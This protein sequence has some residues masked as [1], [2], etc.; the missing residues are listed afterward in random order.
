[1][2]LFDNANVVRTTTER[3]DKIVIEVGLD[4]LVQTLRF[5][6]ADAIQEQID[7]KNRP[8]NIIVDNRNSKPI[9]TATKRIQAF[10]TDVEQIRVAV[11][12]AWKEIQKLTRVK[13]G[14]AIGSYQIWY[15]E[16]PIGTSPSAIDAVLKTFDGSK[17]Y[18]RIVGPLVAYGRKIY[19]RPKNRPGKGRGVV[20]PLKL[21]K[22]V[23]LRTN[24]A[25]FKVVRNKGIMQEVEEIL[26]RRYR[27]VA[28]AEDW[29]NT[30][31]LPK[32]GRTPGLWIGFPRKGALKR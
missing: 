31:A 18:F 13:S 7:I 16:K 10:F 14:L 21:T 22:R 11:Y 25:I 1:M 29:V 17:D 2:G 5:V 15:N 26:R 24:S 4:D 32:D 6:A 28:I 12:A 27:G 9:D 20:K 8:T 19:W 3:L 23:A 30:N